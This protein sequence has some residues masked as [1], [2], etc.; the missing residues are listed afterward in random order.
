MLLSLRLIANSVR[1]HMPSV[2]G[3]NT[4]AAAPCANIIRQLYETGHLGRHSKVNAR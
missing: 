1:A 4:P 3:K 2:S